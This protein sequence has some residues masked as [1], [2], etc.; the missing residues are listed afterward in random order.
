MHMRE[1][2]ADP[3]RFQRFSLN[4]G[5]LLMD[6]SKHRITERTLDCCSS[7]PTPPN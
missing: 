6:Y 3:Q 7:W 4:L 2:F 1:L 5:P